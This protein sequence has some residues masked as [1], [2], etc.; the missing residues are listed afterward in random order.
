MKY[1]FLSLTEKALQLPAH[2]F[3]N[4]EAKGRELTVQ[5]VRPYM[6]PGDK[7]REIIQII[8]SV[9]DNPHCSSL[10]HGQPVDEFDPAL[11]LGGR[12]KNKLSFHIRA[13]VI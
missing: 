9:G 6:I 11:L 5:L 2:S 1:D 10:K 13:L 4:T 8:T 3:G 7:V 12:G